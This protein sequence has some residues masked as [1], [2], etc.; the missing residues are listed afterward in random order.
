MKEVI[1]YTMQETA[2]GRALIAKSEKGICAIF[3]HVSSE[4]LVS[5]LKLHFPST[6][7]EEN[8][9]ALAATAKRVVAYINN[10]QEKFEDHLD[11][12][13]TTFQK[14][15]WGQLG[16]IP[17]GKT[18]SYSDV[19]QRLEVPHA[20]RAVAGACAANVLAVVI[21]CHRVV[22]K[23]GSL[24]GYRWGVERKQKLLEMEGAR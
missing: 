8:D 20:V 24:S 21:P 9:L 3:I 7:I 16:V 12:R 14:K 4:N 5:E 13:G 18:A 2:L 15:V 23:D 11:M 17:V 6:V 22:K 19:A 1:Q 10:P